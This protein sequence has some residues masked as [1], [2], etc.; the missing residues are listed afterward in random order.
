MNKHERI[1]EQIRLT[2]D[3]KEWDSDTCEDIARILERHGYEVR[4]LE[5]Y[6]EDELNSRFDVFEYS[7]CEDCLLYLANGDEPED[8]EGD[9]SQR[10]ADSIER[11]LNGR[12]GTFS[13]GVRP[14]VDDPEGYGFEEFSYSS[15]ELCM[16]TLGGSRY[17]ATLLVEKGEEAAGEVTQPAAT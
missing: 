12:N 9:F 3:G 6:E 17:G 13:P 4:D 7:V 1:I 15:C 8:S 2:L 5:Q 14:T 10:M 11:E 16:S